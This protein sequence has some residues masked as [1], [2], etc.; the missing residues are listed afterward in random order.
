MISFLNI[1][2]Q[3]KKINSYLQKNPFKGFV[4]P[5]KITRECEY[6]ISEITGSKYCI[7]TTSGTIALSLAALSLSLKK[8]DEIIVPSYGVIST[9]NAF[10]SIGFNIKLCEI[11]KKT[12]CLSVQ[13][14]KKI[15]SKKTKAI[16][17]VNFSGYVGKELVNIRN[18]CKKRK[19]YLIEDSACALGNFYNNYSAGTFGDIG[20]FSLSS[21]KTITTGQGGII[22]FKNKKHFQK[23]L[24][25][26]DQG[27]ND[28]RKTNNHKKI[29][30]N[31][32]FND[33]LASFL[34]PQLKEINKI[35][36]KRILIH[37]LMFKGLYRQ[38]FNISKEISPLY[39]IIFTHK[40]YEL[41]RY[42]LSNKI[43]T[44]I[45][46]KRINKNQCYKK[47]TLKNYINSKF[48]EEKALFLPMGSGLKKKD[49]SK[50]NNLLKK[51]KDLLAYL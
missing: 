35:V 32:K 23:A 43:K 51:K 46:Y 6:L 33:I 38:T 50:I 30:T 22:I 28:W 36:K 44:V 26:I 12:G 42:L 2:F 18:F 5:G 15:V 48:W 21:T 3:N 41:Q 25:I 24:E 8:G 7:L 40:R 1:A 20:T 49:A 27:S 9:S 29:G 10:S 17:F 45:Q 47:L 14:L 11:E 39:N 13:Y 37:K 19:I 31:L 4:G 34:Q 16:C